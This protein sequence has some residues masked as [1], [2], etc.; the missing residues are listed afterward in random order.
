MDSRIVSLVLWAR[1]GVLSPQ[2]SGSHWVGC[3]IWRLCCPTG[4]FSTHLGNNSETWRNLSKRNGLSE[5]N[6]S[7]VLL[8]DFCANHSLSII[9]AVFK[10]KDVYKY[11]WHQDTQVT[12]DVIVPLRYITICINMF[13]ALIKRGDDLSPDH[14]LVAG[15]D[16]RQT[17]LT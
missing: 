15:K 8:L 3:S 2:P 9:N 5:L 11:M 14:H 1:E 12:G 10:H 17:W 7:G 16:A 4:E 13:R 6:Q